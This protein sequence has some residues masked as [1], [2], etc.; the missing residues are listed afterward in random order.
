M[1]SDQAADVGQTGQGAEQELAVADF[2][3][4]AAKR[5]PPDELAQNRGQ[6]RGRMIEPR[7]PTRDQQEH[8]HEPDQGLRP[9]ISHRQRPGHRV[10][11]ARLR[12]PADGAAE[13]EAHQE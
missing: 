4:I 11:V 10:I 8:R 5:T 12:A 1:I 3:G 13:Q 9:E 6:D 2:Q 7:R